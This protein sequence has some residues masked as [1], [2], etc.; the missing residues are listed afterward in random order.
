[1]LRTS[2][3]L[4]L[5]LVLAGTARAQSVQFGLVD[6]TGWVGSPVLMEVTVTDSDAAPTAAGN[7][8][9]EVQV[10]PQPASRTSEL[11]FINGQRSTRSKAVWRVRLV[12]KRAGVL[13][14]PPVEVKI[15]DR[16]WRSAA[17][18]VQVAKSDSE[19]TLRLEVRTEPASPWV[20]QSVEVTLRILVR[21]Y[22][23]PNHG[24]VLDEGQMWRLLDAGASSWGAVEPRLRELAQSNRRPAGS[25]EMI[26]GQ[27]WIVYEITQNITTSHP[28]PVD[29]GDLRVVWRYPTGVSVGRDFFGATELTLSGVRPVTATLPTSNVTVRALPEAGRPASFRGAVGNFALRTSAKPTQVSAG[30]PITLT[31]TVEDLGDAGEALKTLQPPPLEVA[32]LGGAFRVPADPLAGTVDGNAKIF[33]QT[34][35]PND[36][37]VTQVPPIEFSFFDPKKGQYVVTRSQPIPVRVSPAERL[38]GDRIERGTA[39]AADTSGSKL[40]EV[41]GGLVANVAPSSELLSDQRFTLGAGT[42]SLLVAPPLLAAVALLAQRRRD[43]LRADTGLARSLGAGRSA[44]SRLATAA[45]LPA[46]CHA[47]TG[48]VADRTSRAEGTVTR[49]QAVQLARDAGAERVLC[50]RLD[51]VLAA[52]ERAGF[53]PSPGSF[54]PA[55]RREAEELLRDLERLRWK[56]KATDSL[57]V[58]P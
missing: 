53:A 44:R 48:F 28:G 36:P 34:I 25:E 47:L 32:T 29:L 16:V 58:H 31:M 38:S 12:P 4:L 27:A 1:M 14:T 24:V 54:D 2:I 43:R 6:T 15:G 33:T 41:E 3:A 20:G 17:K 18:S 46:L 56:R 10:D 23:S 39:P 35:R 51:A 52:G 5:S 22:S 40:T 8:D 21:P 26:D 19:D 45:D 57:E 42:V 30:D 55:Q 11:S 50:E 37:A 7:A 49:G 9:F 13:E